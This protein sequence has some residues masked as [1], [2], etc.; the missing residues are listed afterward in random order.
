MNVNSANTT[1][2]GR[3]NLSELAGVFLKLGATAFGGP[4]AHIAMM[5]DVVVTRRGWLT[6]EDKILGPAPTR[7]ETRAA[8]PRDRASES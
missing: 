3:E 6:R 5:E 1:K 4:A 8:R 7:A 2:P